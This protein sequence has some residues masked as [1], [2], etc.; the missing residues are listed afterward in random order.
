MRATASPC[1]DSGVSAP[2]R[3]HPHSRCPT[4]LPSAASGRSNDPHPLCACPVIWGTLPC[5]RFAPHSGCYVRVRRRA[6]CT[7]WPP[8]RAGD[9]AADVD[10]SLSEV[11]ATSSDFALDRG[12]SGV[13]VVGVV[14]GVVDSLG[15]LMAAPVAT[16]WAQVPVPSVAQSQSMTTTR[17]YELQ[18]RRETS[19]RSATMARFVP[20]SPCSWLRS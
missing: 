10:C 1:G 15:G 16:L 6:L 8:R 19:A 4:F 11:S 12:R 17:R 18:P 3:C 9:A 14:L 13:G 2:T 5:H 20:K 7:D